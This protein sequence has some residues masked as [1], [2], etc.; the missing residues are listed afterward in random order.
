MTDWKDTLENFLEEKG[1]EKKLPQ[2]EEP[3][4]IKIKAFIADI[5]LPAFEQL[6]GE[7]KTYG[8]DAVPVLTV[9]IPNTISERIRLVIKGNGKPSFSYNPKFSISD[10]TIIMTVLISILPSQSLKYRNEHSLLNAS[11]KEISKTKIIE[12]F[13]NAYSTHVERIK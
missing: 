3:T 2:F 8:I 1:I 5:L 13:I 4:E 9:K 11:L 7:L 12:D 6:V 10:E